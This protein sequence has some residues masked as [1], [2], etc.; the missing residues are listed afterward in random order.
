MEIDR[1]T[2]SV[3]ITLATVF[4]G[5]LMCPHLV[6]QIISRTFLNCR[7]LQA[8]EFVSMYM[9]CFLHVCRH[10]HVPLASAHSVTC[11]FTPLSI[12]NE[13]EA[14]CDRPQKSTMHYLANGVVAD[15]RVL[16]LKPSVPVGKGYPLH[17]TNHLI[18]F[19]VRSEM[20]L[21]AD[22]WGHWAFLG[23]LPAVN[24]DS[25][26]TDHTSTSEKLRDA[27]YIPRN[28]KLCTQLYFGSVLRY[29]M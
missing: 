8:C 9:F 1:W 10:C 23:N 2:P 19:W 24:A 25:W 5:G 14:G 15:A 16:V 22:L 17:L 18:L 20:L 11:L 28:C 26:R 12:S 4:V 27:F 13:Y 6:F 21:S 3:I 29:I 7:C